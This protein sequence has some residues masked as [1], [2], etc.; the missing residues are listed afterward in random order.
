MYGSARIFPSDT[1]GSLASHLRVHCKAVICMSIIRGIVWLVRMWYWRWQLGVWDLAVYGRIAISGTNLVIGHS[2]TI[3]DGAILNAL[4]KLSIGNHVRISYHV[5]ILTAGLD[6]T[7]PYQTRKHTQA[8]VTIKDGVWIGA[9]AIILPGVTIGE[10]AIVGAG[11]LVT[12]D[13]SPYTTVVGVPAKPVGSKFP[14][15]D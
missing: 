3:N 14:K 6:A 9:G 5:I 8:P 15:P 7:Q 4:D 1:S 13:V 11:A 10:G 2:C 12:K